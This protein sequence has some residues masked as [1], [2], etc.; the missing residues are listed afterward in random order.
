MLS[1]SSPVARTCT[2]N[3]L[4]NSHQSLANRGQNDAST[5]RTG[6]DTVATSMPRS[7][8]SSFSQRCLYCITAFQPSGRKYGI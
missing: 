2:D 5:Y 4:H 6:D 7:T 1:S 3:L 8:N